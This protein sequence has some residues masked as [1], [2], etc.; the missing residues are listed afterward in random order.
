MSRIIEITIPSQKTEALLADI[1]QMPDLIGLRVQPHIS[2]KPAGDVVTIQILNASYQKYMRLLDRYS[3]G[4]DGGISISTSEPDS[5][6]PTSKKEELDRDSLEASWEEME[7]IIS[8][9]SNATLSTLALTVAAG[10]LAAIGIATGAL[11]IVIG[12][13]LVAPGFMPIMRISLGIITGSGV[14]KKGLIDTVKAYTMIIVV[15]AIS[16]YVMDVTGM[17]PLPGKPSYYE[18]YD[19]LV[20]YWTS[21][22]PSGL[23]SSAAASLAGAIMLCT[24]RST[25]TSGVMIGL[26]LVPSA[27]LIGMGLAAGDGQLAIDATLR[28]LADVALVL[29]VSAAVF[30]IVRVYVHKRT[31]RI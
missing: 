19:T 24:K 23:V 4:H 8:K 25:F 31:M 20:G 30:F 18:F 16:S 17:Q 6:V 28:W 7:H 11:H 26:A 1:K 12:G 29:A 22:K 13:M 21:I 5:L 3:L 27:S 9:D 10:M 2:K 14:W 15:A